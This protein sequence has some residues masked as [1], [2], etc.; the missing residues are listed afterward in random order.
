MADDREFSTEGARD[1][2][3]RDDLAGWV[4]RFLASPG[5]D[6]A[7]LGEQLADELSWWVGPVLLPIDRMHRLAGPPGHP[8]LCPVDEDA[9]DDRPGEIAERVDDG[10]DLPPVILSQRDD[11][12]VLEDG[13]HRV[14]GLRQSGHGR[15]WS[16][17]GFERRQDR[18]RFREQEL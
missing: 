18:D 11:Q 15:A 10:D 1:A 2:A 14:E 5:S 13:N 7:E 6:N 8:V 12:L 3:A 17:V 16:V 9:W 4:Q